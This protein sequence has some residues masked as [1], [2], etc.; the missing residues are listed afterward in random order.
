MAHCPKCNSSGIR[1]S[2]TRSRWERWRKEITSKRPYRCRACQ[3]RGWMPIGLGDDADQ[4]ESWAQSK[5]PGAKL[6]APDPP[7]L[8]GTPLARPDPQLRFDVKTLDR[9]HTPSDKDDV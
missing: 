4:S 9:F 7:N 1:K 8:K 6:A 3:W 5:A 2:P